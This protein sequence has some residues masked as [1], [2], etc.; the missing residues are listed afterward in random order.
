MISFGGMNYFVD[1]EAVDEWLTG[2]EDLQAQEVKDVEIKEFFDNTG[3]KTG[4]EK[5]TRIYHKG[6]EVDGAKFELINF[7][8]QIVLGDME[9]MDDTLG[10]ERAF[11]DKS[12]S[13]KMAFNTLRKWGIIKAIDSE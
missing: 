10:E 13:Y 12:L 1:L 11:S 2:D 6:K 5:T 3:Q 4:S 8:L 7:M 9:P